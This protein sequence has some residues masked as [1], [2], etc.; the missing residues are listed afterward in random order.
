MHDL[1]DPM[2]NEVHRSNDA[3][4]ARD[5]VAGAPQ[6]QELRVGF[7]P[8]TDCAPVVMAAARGFDEAQGIRIVPVKAPSW[9][10]LRDMLLGGAIDLAH[11]LY[12]LPYGLHLG[13]GGLQRPMAVL[14]TLNR[15]GQALTISR[16]LAERGAVDAVSLARLVAQQPR[17]YVF[18]QTFPTGTHAMWLAYWLA[19]AGIDPL[20]D[21]KI[22]TVPPPQMV[23]ELRAGRIDGFSAGEPWNHRAILDGVG[24][25]VATSQQLW[26]NHPEKVLAATASFV[27]AHP[28]AARAAVRALLD[29]GR[30]LDAESRHR[31]VA[32][33]ILARP[34]YV[35]APVEAI[36]PRLLGR[37]QDG[38]GHT[39]DD[40]EPVR[41]FDRGDVTFPYLSDGV[42]FLT[43]FRRWGL[44]REHPDYLGVAR[45]INRIDLYSEAARA[46]GVAVPAEP[47]RTSRLFDGGL[48]DGSD[49]ARY[50][51]GFRI[52]ARAAASAAA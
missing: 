41:F 12:G 26:P 27:D 1:Q 7:L 11:A 13:I 49:P 33:E 4:P 30:W 42:W 24:V 23:E 2:R 3:A 39:W 43:Q 16:A 28:D 46:L 17:E 22:V 35:D 38:R 14:M 19:S 6:R 21:V 37:Y 8:L 47:L 29:A 5:A 15:N 44:L 48:W 52:D 45:S 10:A 50:A 36:L 34:A 25:G 9:A 32:A 51:D 40:A 20:R 31:V 18:A